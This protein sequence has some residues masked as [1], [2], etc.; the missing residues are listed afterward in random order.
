MG[1]WK[2]IIGEGQDEKEV[3]AFGLGTGNE[4]GE[5]LVEFCRQRK[6]VVTNSCFENEKRRRYTWKLPG[7][8]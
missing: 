4:R 1:D 7:D 3:G 2:C 8:T 6:L 5:I